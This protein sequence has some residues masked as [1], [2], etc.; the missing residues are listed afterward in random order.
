MYNPVRIMHS[1]RN[2]TNNQSGQYNANPNV[3]SDTDS[4][5]RVNQAGTYLV[6]AHVRGTEKN[7]ADTFAVGVNGS[8]TNTN[9]ENTFST[10]GPGGQFSSITTQLKLNAGDEVGVFLVSQG[11][12]T[13]VP[14][15]TSAGTRGGAAPSTG[16]SIVKIA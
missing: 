12:F 10:D 7:Q 5:I 15:L 16:L 3:L 6:T 8:V 2:A 4:G 14:W 9:T 13:T 1:P 11:T